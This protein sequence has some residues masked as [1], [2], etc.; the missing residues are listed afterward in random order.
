VAV[1]YA[2]T[3][4]A[5]DLNV[6]TVG[7][8]DTTSSISSVTDTRGN[9]Y[10]LAVGP[11]TNTGLQ[12]SVYYAKNIA[13]GSNTVTVKFNQAA[14]YPDVRILEYSGLNTSTPL[15]GKAAASGSGTTANSGA[16]TTTSANELIF[17]AGTTGTAFTA[18]GSGFVNRMINLF[19]NI[20]EDKTVTSTGSYSATATTTS[21]V[22]VMQVVTFK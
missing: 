16:A 14:S 13:S 7:W 11:T 19:G 17:G 5:G 21:S 9:T 15:D 1:A 10:T 8:G 18:A 22:W 12:Q 4:V 6:V 2:S 3:Q 20:A